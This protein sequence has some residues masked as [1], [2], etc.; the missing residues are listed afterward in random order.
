MKKLLFFIICLP[1]FLPAQNYVP[2]S[3]FGNGGR[4]WIAGITNNPQ[5]Q[6]NNIF[7][8][9][10]YLNGK[11]DSNFRNNGFP[12]LNV[13]TITPESDFSTLIYPN[14]ISTNATLKYTLKEDSKI[15]ISLY[16]IEGKLIKTFVSGANRGAGEHIQNLNTESLPSG[17]YFLTIKNQTHEKSISIFKN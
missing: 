6:S 2:D 12:D 5:T 8:S 3:S 16:N 9:N 17:N 7:I 11:I 14:P 10:L 15:N 4:V 13:G 1:F